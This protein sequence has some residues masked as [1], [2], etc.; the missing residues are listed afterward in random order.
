[1]KKKT[2]NKTKKKKEKEK[3]ITWTQNSKERNAEGVANNIW[4]AIGSTGVANNT[5][6]I[7]AA[8]DQSTLK[9]SKKREKREKQVGRRSGD[10]RGDSK[11]MKGEE[12]GAQGRFERSKRRNKMKDINK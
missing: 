10:W 4:W 9:I 11:M 8:V 1:M 2:E 5:L 12:V 3:E 7:A 6:P